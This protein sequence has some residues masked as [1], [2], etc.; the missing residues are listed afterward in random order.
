[1]SEILNLLGLIAPIF[2]LIGVGVFAR[3][4]GWLRVEADGSLLRL[5]VTIF[6]PCLILKAVV[7]NPGLRDFGSIAFPA[8]TGFGSVVVGLALAYAVGR[9]FKFKKGHGLRTFA[10]AVAIYN[11]GYMAAPLVSELF[12]QALGVLFVFNFGI[13]VALWTVGM[14]MM[15]GGSLREAW[16]KVLNPT[17]IGLVCGLILNAFAP[18]CW[19]PQ[20]VFTGISM[21]G[22]CAVTLGLI[23]VGAILHE[24]FGRPRDLFDV[25]ASFLGIALKLGV[26]PILFLAAA[27]FLPVAMEIKQVLVVQAAM[28]SGVFTIALA[29]HYGGHLVTAVRV[30]FAT[31]VA[32]ILLTPLWL[33]AGLWLMEKM[34]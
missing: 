11:Y 10:V 4:A 33:R 3:A 34:R 8:L 19:L 14:V 20:F 24:F 30:I 23:M 13:D 5:V 21:L 6:Y 31:T 28:P 18:E 26:L 1:M 22:G 17:V 15:A 2:C 16:R 9:L 25:R 7:G 29:R 27:W 32:S 12:P